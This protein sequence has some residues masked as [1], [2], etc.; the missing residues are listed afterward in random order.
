MQDSSNGIMKQKIKTETRTKDGGIN[1]SS[2][3]V[4]Y[5]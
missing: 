2:V 4:T 1:K 3:L 5:R